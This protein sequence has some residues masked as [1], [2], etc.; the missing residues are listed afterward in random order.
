MRAGALTRRRARAGLSE[1]DIKRAGRWKYGARY[2]K[3][4]DLI[5]EGEGRNQFYISFALKEAP[6]RYQRWNS[7][8]TVT[9][10]R[11]VFVPCQL[12]TFV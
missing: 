2:R 9:D 6:S 11:V 3:V 4:H 7:N 12:G 5:A 1:H 10:I 8:G